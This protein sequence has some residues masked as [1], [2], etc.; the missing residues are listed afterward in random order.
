MFQEYVLGFLAPS[1]R[2]SRA[3]TAGPKDSPSDSLVRLVVEEMSILSGRSG[4]MLGSVLRPY[5]CGAL[6][7]PTGDRISGSP[8]NPTVHHLHMG[9]LIKLLK[10]TQTPNVDTRKVGRLI[11]GAQKSRKDWKDPQETAERSPTIGTSPKFRG[12]INA[13]SSSI[14]T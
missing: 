8:K 3:S 9:S 7:S 10:K 6:L 13:P 1:Q 12:W 11:R 2:L 4:R 5:G 14:I